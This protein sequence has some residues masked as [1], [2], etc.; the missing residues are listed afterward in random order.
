VVNT[1]RSY[2]S[3]DTYTERKAIFGVVTRVDLLNFI[4]NNAPK[5]DKKKETSSEEK[6]SS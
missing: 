6:K 1:Q 4:L 2:S 5:D 3:K